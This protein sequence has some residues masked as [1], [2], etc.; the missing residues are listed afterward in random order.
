MIWN[1]HMNEQNVVR[2]WE[3]LDLE[4]CFTLQPPQLFRI[5]IEALKR[6]C[7]QPASP[8]TKYYT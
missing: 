6:A 7:D 4:G 3:K 2:F 5:D 1:K 8:L